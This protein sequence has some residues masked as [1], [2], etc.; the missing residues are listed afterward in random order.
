MILLHVIHVHQIVLYVM[1]L[2][3]KNVTLD[4]IYYQMELAVNVQEIVSNALLMN[5]Q[6]VNKDI[7]LTDSLAFHAS[8]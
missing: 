5:A 1:Q 7:I 2:D 3:V 8:K 6:S 4:I